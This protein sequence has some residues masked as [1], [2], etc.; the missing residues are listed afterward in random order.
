MGINFWTKGQKLMRSLNTNGSHYFARPG[1]NWKELKC[2]HDKMKVTVK[3]T[4][5]EDVVEGI[6]KNLVFSEK[7]IRIICKLTAWPL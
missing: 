7:T 5:N 6:F 4:Q 1:H 3:L 2:Q